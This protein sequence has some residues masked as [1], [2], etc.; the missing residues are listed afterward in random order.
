MEYKDYYKILGVEKNATPDEIKNKYRRLA[1]KYH[2]DVSTEKDA[3]ENFK[4]VREAY[5]VLKDP[6]KRKAYDQ[7][8]SEWQAGEQFRRPPEWNYQSQTSG[9]EQFAD[10]DFSEF[11]ANLFGQ[12]AQHGRQAHRQAYNQQGQDQHSKIKLSLEDAFSG[13]E[14]MIQLQE[15]IHDPQS[16]EIKYQT[17]NLKIKIPAGVTAGQHIRFAGLGNKGIGS[18]ANGDLYLEIEM[19]DHPYYT[20]KNRDIYLN[21]PVTPW[22]AA[23]GAKIEVPTLAGTVALTIPAGSQTG[24]KLRLAGRG[25]PG[26]PGGDQFATL[27]IYTPEPKTE[28]QRQLYQKMAEEMHYNPRQNLIR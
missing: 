27:S 22:E 17:R 14:R 6:K 15:P 23:L 1:R 25:L 4:A 28:S 3:E 2:P 8:G 26:K 16:G 24:S 19:L 18:G 11:F 12:R 5:E 13:S 9:S 10:E 21:L 7:M 20:V